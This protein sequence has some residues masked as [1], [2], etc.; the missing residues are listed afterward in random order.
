[1]SVNAVTHTP[2]LGP[3]PSAASLQ[4][5]QRSRE[6][7]PLTSAS[8]EPAPLRTRVVFNPR[9]HFDSGAG[10]FVMEYRD[11]TTGEV[12]RQI[13]DEKQL[14]AYA[15]AK[16]LSQPGNSGSDRD[17][18][19]TGVGVAAAATDRA[20]AGR[21]SAWSPAVPAQTERADV[22]EQAGVPKRAGVQ[23]LGSVPERISVKV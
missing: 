17:P 11:T 8:A 6:D 9:S 20:E 12:E 5:M 3:P 4:G 23:E 10:V 7:S 13:P 21:D 2:S 19:A 15:D 16:K 1:M 22:P 18:R 14:R